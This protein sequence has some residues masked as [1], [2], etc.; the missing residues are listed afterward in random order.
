MIGN[1]IGQSSTTTNPVVVSYGA[2][3]SVWPRNALYLVNNTLLSDAAG[4]WFLRVVTERFPAG[5]DVVA[6]NNLTVGVGLFTLAAPGH[7][8]GNFPGAWECPG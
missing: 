3:G 7:F 2:E 1:I 6:T 5:V 4:A 8:E